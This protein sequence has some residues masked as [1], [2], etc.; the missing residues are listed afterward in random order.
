[1]IVRTVGTIGDLS[2]LSIA[3]A[4]VSTN[5]SDDETSALRSYLTKLICQLWAK[6]VSLWD[7]HPPLNRLKEIQ[8]KQCRELLTY[9]HWWIP[10]TTT[11]NQTCVFEWL[12]ERLE[13]RER[14]VGGSENTWAIT[15]VAVA[16]DAEVF[17]RNGVFKLP[18]LDPPTHMADAVLQSRALVI[19]L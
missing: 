17:D 16:L 8:T 13:V 6:R 11:T 15:E 4:H 14:C 1:M 5:A 2:W 10:T 19:R 9:D 12:K 18:Y 7:P 3:A